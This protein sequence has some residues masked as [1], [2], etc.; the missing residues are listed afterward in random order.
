MCCKVIRIDHRIC[1]LVVKTSSV[2][3]SLA[4]SLFGFDVH[5]AT[6]QALACGQWYGTDPLCIQLGEDGSL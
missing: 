3:V 6:D 4:G 2:A 1:S 5:H